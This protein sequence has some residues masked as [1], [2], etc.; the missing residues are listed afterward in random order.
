M[1]L[2]GAGEG[3]GTERV[4][5]ER[6]LPPVSAAA[7]NPICPQPSEPLCHSLLFASVMDRPDG[8]G[9]PWPLPEKVLAP[10]TPQAPGSPGAQA[11]KNR[12][13]GVI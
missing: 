6:A 2:L 8:I 4:W 7:G 9:E 12:G 5:A 3:G 1:G 10:G 13:V 11:L